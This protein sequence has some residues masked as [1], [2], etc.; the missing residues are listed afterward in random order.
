MPP[1]PNFAQILSSAMLDKY[2]PAHEMARALGVSSSVLGKIVGA[3]YTTTQDRTSIGLDLKKNGQYYLLGYARAKDNGKDSQQAADKKKQ[4]ENVWSR[5]DAITVVGSSVKA[6]AEA[7][8]EQEGPKQTWEYSTRTLNLLLEYKSLFPTV[9]QAIGANPSEKKYAP[10]A[11]FPKDSEAQFARL[12]D[13]IN[14]NAAL[15]TPR[16]PLT[17]TGLSREVISGIERAVDVRNSYLSASGGEKI[18]VTKVPLDSIV[19]G[20]NADVS[21]IPV[22]LNKSPPSLGDRVINLSALGVPFGMRGTVVTIHSSTGFVEVL[23]DEEFTGGRPVQ[24]S[25]SLFRGRLCP[26]RGLLLLGKDGTI[27]MDINKMALKTKVGVTPAAVIKK[28]AAKA[29][30]P[31]AAKPATAAAPT[32]VMPPTAP[33]AGRSALLQAAQEGASQLPPPPQGPLDMSGIVQYLPV[34]GKQ[35][36]AQDKKAADV[37]K[38]GEKDAHKKKP[39]AAAKADAAPTSEGGAKKGLGLKP[40]A[41]LLAAVKKKKKEGDA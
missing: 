38:K 21:D 26:W 18:R 15:K 4:Q 31:P 27:A 16:T 22:N 28:A 41:M 17:T 19:R 13:W 34:K 39:P 2:Y 1:E 20:G 32:P 29:A 35:Y 25:N 9:F 5:S 24:G 10:S 8:V 30:T 37:A 12:Q 7:E 3:V 11:L 6:E 36:S 40:A 14:T 33:S 23:F